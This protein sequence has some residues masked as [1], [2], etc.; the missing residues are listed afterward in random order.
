MQTIHPEVLLEA[1]RQG[2]FPMAHEGM[3]EWYSPVQRGIIPLDERFHIPRGL[4]RTLKKAPFDIRFD[5][6][7]QEVMVACAD[8]EETWID[9]VILN[10]YCDLHRLGFTH[11]VE[12]W[13]EEGLQGGL[14]GVA[15]PGIFFGESM[16]SRKTDS[17]KFALVALVERM[18]E[19]GFTLLDTQWMTPHLEQFGGYEMSRNEYFRCLGESLD[20]GSRP[21]V[22]SESWRT[23]RD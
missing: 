20:L 17:S 22:S 9:E 21:L 14:Y 18:R 8:R 16:F 4:R 19:R 7:F 2:V 6:A 3:I 5:S 15:L 11:S 10:S 1:Y 23:E 13:D 12:S